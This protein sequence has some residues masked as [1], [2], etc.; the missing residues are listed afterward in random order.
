MVIEPLIQQAY[1]AF[2][3]RDIDAALLLMTPNVD[4]PN[5]WEGGYV[6]GQDEVRAYWTRQ[7]NEIDPLVDPLSIIQQPDGRIKVLVH[8]TVKDKQGKLLSDGHVYH[9]YTIENGLIKTMEIEK[10]DEQ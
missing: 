6:H 7:W 2:N 10:G 3:K 1:D 5:G 9:I 4:W 8:Q